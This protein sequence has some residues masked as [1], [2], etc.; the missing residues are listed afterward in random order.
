MCVGVC[1]FSEWVYRRKTDENVSTRLQLDFLQMGCASVRK[2]FVSLLMDGLE[3]ILEKEKCLD[4]PHVA[5]AAEKC[6][7]HFPTRNRNLDVGCTPVA[8]CTLEEKHQQN[9]TKNGKKSEPKFRKV[10]IWAVTR[11]WAGRAGPRPG[12]SICLCK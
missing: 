6:E 8:R 9:P 7:I 5:V 2:F 12:P 4:L 10:D 3:H 1:P 11:R